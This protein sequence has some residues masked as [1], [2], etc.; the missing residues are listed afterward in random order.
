MESLATC[1]PRSMTSV[2][3]A[4]RPRPR[5]ALCSASRLGTPAGIPFEIRPLVRFEVVCSLWIRRLVLGAG[6]GI[7]CSMPSYGEAN[8]RREMGLTAPA[9][10]AAPLLR[11]GPVAK[12]NHQAFGTCSSDSFISFGMDEH[13]NSAPR[14]HGLWCIF[15]V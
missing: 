7:G 3:R 8:Q 9:N 2:P 5:P 15:S 10:F 6:L 12:V 13:F 4:L 14:T 1:S 11:Y